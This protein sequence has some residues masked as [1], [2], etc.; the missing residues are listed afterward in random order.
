MNGEDRLEHTRCTGPSLQVADIALGR[1]KP[2]AATF[3]H[4]KDLAQTLD[5]GQV[6]DASAGAVGL[7]QRTGSRIKPGIAP[8]PL[9]GV[10]LADRVRCGDPLALTVR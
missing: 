1:A 6:T 2:D 4:P 7:D 5:F 10:D 9:N 3:R 8:G